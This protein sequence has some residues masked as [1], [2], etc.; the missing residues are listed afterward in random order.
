MIIESG[1]IDPIWGEPIT[2]F[3]TSSSIENEPWG[4]NPSN[5]FAYFRGSFWQVSWCQFLNVWQPPIY[6]PISNHHGL[7]L[8]ERPYQH[9]PHYM[10]LPLTYWGH[11]LREHIRAVDLANRTHEHITPTVL[12]NWILLDNWIFP[13]WQGIWEIER[14][15]SGERVNW[16]REGF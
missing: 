5:R 1:N 2:L 4:R 3:C 15:G 13:E 7:M 14:F 10:R 9:D 12:D 11:L 8:R 6:Y 16:Q